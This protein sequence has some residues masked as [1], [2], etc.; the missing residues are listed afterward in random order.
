MQPHPTQSSSSLHLSPLS[1]SLHLP[2]SPTYLLHPHPVICPTQIHPLTPT[3]TSFLS[4]LSTL[5]R[6]TYLRL[7]LH[8]SPFL[9]SLP[10]LQPPSSHLFPPHPIQLPS[11]PTHHPLPSLPSPSNVSAA[12]YS[13]QV[14]MSEFLMQP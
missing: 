6:S 11:S 10:P 13:L 12:V 8:V 4:P 7:S 9:P 14:V 5:P 2:P 1:P 3:L